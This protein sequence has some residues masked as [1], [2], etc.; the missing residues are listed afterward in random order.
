M[1]GENH[2]H[3]FLLIPNLC[4]RYIFCSSILPQAHTNMNFTETHFHFT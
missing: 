1:G 4:L 2:N 3:L